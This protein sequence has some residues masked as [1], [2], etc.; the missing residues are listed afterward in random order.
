[1]TLIGS[2]QANDRW[3]FGIR[4]NLAGGI[5]YTPYDIERSTLNN[6]AILDQA[7]IYEDR[8]PLYMTFNLRIERRFNFKR[9][10]LYLYLGALNLLNR[11]NLDRYFWDRI[12]NKKGSIYQAPL[13][14]VFGVEYNF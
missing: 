13:L 9:S 10:Q 3:G 8:Y 12:E 14:P 6:R 1:V 2:Y 7:R 11:K 5:P 4:W